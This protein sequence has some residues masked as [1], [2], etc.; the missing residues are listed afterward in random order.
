MNQ[1]QSEAKWQ[2]AVQR[3]AS[4]ELT[5]VS[6]QKRGKST[7]TC[8]SSL[9]YPDRLLMP[10]SSVAVVNKNFI[11]IRIIDYISQTRLRASFDRLPDSDH[12]VEVSW[13][14][15]HGDCMVCILDISRQY[16]HSTVKYQAQHCS[17]SLGGRSFRPLTTTSDSHFVQ[18][19]EFCVLRRSTLTPNPNVPLNPIA[20]PTHKAQRSTFKQYP[21]SK[22]S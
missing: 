1:I 19:S 8:L 20:K 2:N 15:T 17:N 10:W 21:L 14:I 9:T 12:C 4:K 16:P 5:I 7:W 13:A 6:S 11:C 18:I 3:D 22:P